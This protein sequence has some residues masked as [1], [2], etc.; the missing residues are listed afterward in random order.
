MKNTYVI[1]GREYYPNKET[2]Y[3][4]TIFFES[5]NYNLIRA[6]FDKLINGKHEDFSQ[7]A[8]NLHNIEFCLS[9]ISDIIPFRAITQKNQLYIEFSISSSTKKA[10]NHILPVPREDYP[11]NLD[12]PEA[13]EQAKT[14]LLN[15]N[16]TDCT[17]SLQFIRFIEK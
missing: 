8:D 7:E 2:P 9:R 15:H 14:F 13:I 1:V 16:P 10:E 11:E 17:V 3:I 4:D 5:D 6:E 12:S